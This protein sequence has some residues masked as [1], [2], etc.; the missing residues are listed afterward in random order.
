MPQSD[1][2][3]YEALKA[4]LAKFGGSGEKAFAEPFRKPKSDGT[5][6]PIVKKVKLCEKAT[7]SVPVLDGKGA[8]DND[9]MVRIDVFFVEN[10]GYY[11]VPVYV[12]DTIRS[13]LPDRACVHSKPY[14]EWKRMDD[15]NFVFSLYP[16]DLIR[17]TGKKG[18]KL[19][20]TNTE[21]TLPPSYETK[22]EFLYYKGA[23]I[24]TASIAAITHDGAYR[25]EGLGIK[26]LVRLEKYTVDVLGNYSRVGKETRQGF[27]IKRG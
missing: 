8:A 18:L 6:G 16:N 21:S 20:L 27:N 7:L 9:S 23:N 24:S 4:Q 19:R 26:T 11:F 12:S 13:E 17:V 10:D 14:S 15:R 5:P 3:L 1:R 25:L 22:S 2:L